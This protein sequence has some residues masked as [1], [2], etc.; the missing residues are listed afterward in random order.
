MYLSEPEL[1]HYG[2]YEGALV[3]RWNNP[4]SL[5]MGMYIFLSRDADDRVLKHEY[6]HCIQ[7]EILGP[8]YLIAVG[9][10]SLI[11]CNC[12][13]VSKKW[14]CGQRSYYSVYPENWADSL[15]HAIEK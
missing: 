8:L 15:G 14:K 4:R 11:W 13:P 7:S 9:I 5:S 6:G 10:P 1:N 2:D 3:V 12:K